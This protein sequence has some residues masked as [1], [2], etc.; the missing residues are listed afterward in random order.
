MVKYQLAGCCQIV[1]TEA[2]AVFPHSPGWQADFHSC[3]NMRTEPST[4]PQW[5]FAASTQS[6]VLLPQQRVVDLQGVVGTAEAAPFTGVRVSVLAGAASLRVSFFDDTQWKSP[7][8]G[9]KDHG[10]QALGD[11]LTSTDVESDQGGNIV[12]TI[13]FKL[14]ELPGVALVHRGGKLMVVFERPLIDTRNTTDL[15]GSENHSDDF[16]MKRPIFSV[17]A[18]DVVARGRPGVSDQEVSVA[19]Q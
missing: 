4:Y 1:Q 14:E 19:L 6:R 8:D 5:V 17:A 7:R 11:W 9:V 16:E 10:S 15:F 12:K 18:Q 2:K 13:V 3:H